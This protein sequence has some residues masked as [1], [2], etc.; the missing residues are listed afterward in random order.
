MQAIKQHR[1]INY[2]FRYFIFQKSITNQRLICKQKALKISPF[3]FILFVDK[4][5]A[6]AVLVNNAFSEKVHSFYREI[7]RVTFKRFI[8]FN[9]FVFCQDY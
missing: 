2:L 4:S 5:A 1:I 8:D 6:F 7:L 9:I 3:R